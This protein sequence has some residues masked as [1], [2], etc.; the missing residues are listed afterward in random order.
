MI[1]V[2][3]FIT[4]IIRLFLSVLKIAKTI[5]EFSFASIYVKLDIKLVKKF[6]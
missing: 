1:Y 4:K 5:I 2:L 3:Y 6:N